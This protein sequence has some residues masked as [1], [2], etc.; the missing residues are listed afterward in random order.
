M[1]ILLEALNSKAHI[2]TGLM[3]PIPPIRVGRASKSLSKSPGGKWPV[4][5]GMKVCPQEVERDLQY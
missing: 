3:I 4:T 5:A 1:V 2:L